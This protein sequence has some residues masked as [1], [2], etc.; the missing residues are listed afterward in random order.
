MGDDARPEHFMCSYGIPS[1]VLDN[2]ERPAFFDRSFIVLDYNM[3]SKTVESAFELPQGVEE[4]ATY[5]GAVICKDVKSVPPRI[6]W[7]VSPS[8]TA[9]NK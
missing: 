5:D 6:T 8:P 9:R 1:K 7:F 4:I 3:K 2:V